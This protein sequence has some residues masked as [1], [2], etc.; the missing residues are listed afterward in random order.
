M[1]Y[2][3]LNQVKKSSFYGRYIRGRRG[4]PYLMKENNQNKTKNFFK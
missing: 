1:G 4:A 3:K 2:I